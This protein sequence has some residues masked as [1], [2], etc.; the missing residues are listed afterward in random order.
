MVYIITKKYNHKSGVNRAIG[1]HIKNGSHYKD[2]MKKRG[3]VSFEKNEA[4]VEEKKKKLQEPYGP[5]SKKCQD[6]IRECRDT[7]KN[8]KIKMSGRQIKRY[9]E[10]GCSIRVPKVPKETEK[11]GFE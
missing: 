5:P 10:L 7:S 1:V 9:Q 4:Q 11:G 2:E 6:F 3:L 8:G